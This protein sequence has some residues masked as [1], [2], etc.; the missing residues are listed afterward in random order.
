MQK[1]DTLTWNPRGKGCFLLWVT[2][3][4]TFFGGEVS[5]LGLYLK[6]CFTCFAFSFITVIAILFFLPNLFTD[7]PP[8]FHPPSFLSTILKVSRQA[9]VFT[10]IG[11][12]LQLSSRLPISPPHMPFTITSDRP[13]W[14]W[15]PGSHEWT[16]PFACVGWWHVA[17][18]GPC[19]CVGGWYDGRVWAFCEFFFPSRKILG[20]LGYVRS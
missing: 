19:V 16:F 15:F 18:R 5:L 2:K 11:F 3:T 1:V 14:R 9:G 8:R 4:S 10:S 17:L 12:P 20:M 7:P 6:K 13:L